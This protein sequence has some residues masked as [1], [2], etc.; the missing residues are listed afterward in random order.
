MKLLLIISV[1]TSISAIKVPNAW[2]TLPN[3]NNV[4]RD[5]QPR[6]QQ[7]TLAQAVPDYNNINQ[8]INNVPN[9]APNGLISNGNLFGNLA[10]D[11]DWFNAIA[12]NNG[13]VLVNPPNHISNANLQNSINPLA[14]NENEL[15]RDP[16][17]QQ[18]QRPQFQRNYNRR[19]VVPNNSGPASYSGVP[20]QVPYITYTTQ[21]PASQ[22]VA[23]NT[24]PSQAV[25]R[26][27][28]YPRVNNPNTVLPITELDFSPLD[29]FPHSN[30]DGQAAT[31]INNQNTLFSTSQPINTLNFNLHNPFARNPQ[32]NGY[33]INQ[34]PQA[35]QVPSN[36]LFHAVTDN[37]KPTNNPTALKNLNFNPFTKNYRDHR[38]H[39]PTQ[40][41]PNYVREAVPKVE[42]LESEKAPIVNN[43]EHTEDVPTRPIYPGEGQWAKPGFKHRPFVSKQKY[44]NLEEPNQQPDGYDTFL[45]AQ[46]LFEN[47]KK[48]FGL[49]LQPST[50]SSPTQQSSKEA[51]TEESEIFVPT[52]LYAQ[53]RHSEDEKHL[54]PESDENG[55]LKELVKD[56]KVQTI[57][58]EEGFEDSAY[59]HAGHEKKA[60]N[61]EDFESDEK[62]KELKEKKKIPVTKVDRQSASYSIGDQDL[63][64]EDIEKL[65]KEELNL[66]DE[67]DEEDDDSEPAGTHYEEESYLNKIIPT[68]T[69]DGVKKVD[70]LIRP[71][72]VKTVTAKAK[73][74]EN[75]E[76]EIS[77]EVKAVPQPNNS[78][79][80]HKYVKIYPKVNKTVTAN[81]NLIEPE[82][83]T[84]HY[85]KEGKLDAEKSVLSLNP[86]EI[87][88]EEIINQTNSDTA[89]QE[90]ISTT[91]TPTEY[92]EIVTMEIPTTTEATTSLPKLVVKNE[93]Q[94]PE[95]L[96]R[97]EL[98]L[99]ARKKRS[100]DG[101]ATIEID[102]DFIDEINHDIG[103]PTEKSNAPIENKYPYYK[104]YEEKGLNENS[105]LRYA[106]DLQNAPKKIEGKLAFY[107]L[108]DKKM[109]CSDVNPEVDP[110]P[111]RIKN[112]DESIEDEEEDEG[113]DPATKDP[114]LGK[115]GDKIDC[116][117]VKYFGENPLDNPFFQEKLVGPVKPIFSEIENISTK[118]TEDN[119][120]RRSNTQS[121]KNE[122]NSPINANKE[123]ELL[124]VAASNHGIENEVV[125]SLPYKSGLRSWSPG[126][127]FGL[128]E[129]TERDSKYTNHFVEKN[130]N[131]IVN[132]ELEPKQ[133]KISHNDGD[134]MN[135]QNFHELPPLI[136]TPKYTIQLKPK[137]IYDQIELLEYLP[138]DEF[139]EVK[140]AINAELPKLNITEVTTS[141]PIINKTETVSNAPVAKKKK[142]KG[143]K[144][145]KRRRAKVLKKAEESMKMET[146]DI[147]KP[148]SFSEADTLQLV[149][150]PRNPSYE[151]FD[152]NKFIPKP[153]PILTNIQPSRKISIQPSRP[154]Y[155]IPASLHNPTYH[156]FDINKFLPTTPFPIFKD[157]MTR[158]TV[159]PKYKVI[160]EVFYKDDIKPN[161]Q[162]NV[163]TDVLK[164]IKNFPKPKDDFQESS[165]PISVK[166]NAEKISEEFA[167]N[168]FEKDNKVLSSTVTTIISTLEPKIQAS[169]HKYPQVENPVGSGKH[170]KKRKKSKRRRR[171]KT[172]TQ[173]TPVVIEQSTSTLFIRE[174]TEV[175]GL[176]PPIIQGYKTI[177][178]PKRDN[179]QHISNPTIRIEER[180]INKYFVQGMRPPPKQRVY[181]YSDF[182]TDNHIGQIM[183]KP[184]RN[185]LR[186]KRSAQRPA[187]AQVS[188]NNTKQP[189][190]E[191][192]KEE[193][194]YV[195]QR[196][197]NYHYDEKTGKIIY[198]K[199]PQEQTE[200]EEEVEYIEVVE[201][202]PKTTEKPKQNPVF[203]TATPPP[204]GQSYTDF[205]KLLKS[206][207]NYKEIPD[208]TTTEKGA[209]EV[210]QKMITST[211]TSVSTNPPEFLSILAKV[212]KD[213]NYKLIE[214]KKKTTTTP[215]PTEEEEKEEEAENS[216]EESQVDDVR[217]S[218]GGYETGTNLEIFD[219]SDFLPNIKSYLPKT[220]IDT[221][222]YKT[223]ER[224]NVR[225]SSNS[226]ED[227][228]KEPIS[229]TEKAAASTEQRQTKEQAQR[230]SASIQTKTTTPASEVT[231]QKIIR[232]SR[233]RTTTA[234]T[235]EAQVDAESTT[236][237]TLTADGSSA[238]QHD[239]P[240]RNY[241]RRP[242]RIKTTPATNDTSEVVT[243]ASR[244]VR[245]RAERDSNLHAEGNEKHEQI[246]ERN[247]N[248]PN[249]PIIMED[250]VDYE[251]PD[252]VNST[253]EEQIDNVESVAKKVVDVFKNYNKEQ[254]HGGN[255]KKEDEI[256]EQAEIAALEEQDKI[257]ES[258]DDMKTSDKLK[259]NG[260]EDTIKP[261]EHIK[262]VP[263]KTDLEDVK[264]V[265]VFKNYDKSKKHGGNYRPANDKINVNEQGESGLEKHES[266]QI[267]NVNVFQDYDRTKKHGGNYKAANDTLEKQKTNGQLENPVLLKNIDVFK[268]YDKTKKHGGNYRSE[269]DTANIQLESPVQLKKVEIF[270]DYDKT[271]KHGGNYR[272]EN[273]PAN[274]KLENPVLLKNVEVF[275]DYNKTKKHGGNYRSENDSAKIKLENP[276]LLKNVE[277]Y[278]DYDKTKKHGGNYRSKS[279]EAIPE[280]Q[281]EESQFGSP[282]VRINNFN[283][284]TEKK[285]SVEVFK[286]YD[287]AKHHGGNYRSENDSG[288]IKLEN[289]VLLKNVE[290]FKNYDNTKKH[291]GNYR[292]ENDERI[293]EQQLEESQ[294]G[295]PQV[296]QNNL[297]DGTEKKSSVEVFKDYDKTKK[298]GGNYMRENESTDKA[299]TLENQQAIN[300]AKDVDVFKNYDETKKTGGNY[301]Q[302]D[303]I[304]ELKADETRFSKSEIPVQTKRY[305]ENRNDVQKLANAVP[306]P[307]E[308][309]SDL[310]LP[311]DINA[312]KIIKDLPNEELEEIVNSAEDDDDGTKEGVR[313][314]DQTARVITIGNKFK[315]PSFVEGF[316]APT[317]KPFFIK[318]P[319]KRLYFYAPV[320]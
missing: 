7:E 209:E 295:S 41:D 18:K 96:E 95:G 11:Y 212:R 309:Y 61:V 79:K 267:A 94:P 204:E 160:S 227:T 16:Y 63:K 308:I 320:R 176:M 15:R 198:D 75:I 257:R 20:G 273:D 138:E 266:I 112:A 285:S 26:K 9:T 195:P 268:D 258:V 159:L 231:S 42:R 122:P 69:T 58:S 40:Y 142:K 154:N 171:I 239:K 216:E 233:R 104:A 29:P 297:N 207:S 48:E 214:D 218:P 50:D 182:L 261:K 317:K 150:K 37:T 232:L 312:L 197:R 199:K 19:P 99:Q 103:K 38:T 307:E 194:D 89:E 157:L 191:A 141:S 215:K 27:Q 175:M 226:E 184:N 306:K 110:V 236:Q 56:T 315:I 90:Y 60:E 36:K 22:L 225:H 251:V 151:I 114:R 287:K 279:E 2:P 115:L 59:D 164:H 177:Y 74:G 105:P 78:T 30:Q 133:S 288:N 190:A 66:E 1:F 213:N 179:A 173:E 281:L 127:N 107:D 102:T 185:K 44:I 243:E 6:R 100:A 125:D 4:N 186:S 146:S 275:K 299:A 119:V 68:K 65:K 244:I 83:N 202:A 93:D 162:L 52:R 193:D 203:A 33:Q 270:K 88:I 301:R 131:P 280:Q 219:I 250:Y 286:D 109:A 319:S 272:S 205:V 161:E 24:V 172:T 166:L 76:M 265:E 260:T 310:K 245:R 23:F 283:D 148:E 314:D 91:A 180:K 254:K 276:V 217:N 86:H 296:R 181:L 57:Y 136:T 72:E 101:I 85:G 229:K 238:V 274:I 10:T 318:D 53:V 252:N 294:F 208:P 290:I 129:N 269:N 263:K 247:G 196:S 259:K 32:I 120:G 13:I 149:M 304:I 293:P 123:K 28:A 49:K 145:G 71:K 121:T 303:E 117:K 3:Q 262:T 54:P 277:V 170:L 153:P 230:Q 108:A 82:N 124:H 237:T 241:R 39:E 152:I 253:S 113:N 111:D 192:K 187:Y 221:S 302:E 256:T 139:E 240:R 289:P 174:P 178:H 235:I 291:G 271:K 5:S 210:T 84:L 248:V 97:P 165:E 128:G 300:Q 313:E 21:R 316:A 206:A 278:K 106:E 169:N 228:N 158:T 43:H 284:G 163:F 134:K 25:N 246:I 135:V 62:N 87:F 73:T 92:T 188:R 81:I 12:P 14:D 31:Q 137:H 34:F 189:D 143:K 168:L 98:K 80:F 264:K 155:I 298:H 17:A 64:K 126:K 8:Y 311:L 55:R 77:S 116:F 249:Q 200:E 130:P 67:D 305:V 242:T 183:G 292:P 222:K 118:K 201:K 255:Y 220:S 211:P 47:Q 147:K 70:A 223:I 51:N 167:Q 35:G 234:N 282:Q 156:I 132:I 144:K 46:K 224:P 140:K 45:E